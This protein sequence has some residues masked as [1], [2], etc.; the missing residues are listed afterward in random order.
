MLCQRLG[1]I[2]KLEVS[3]FSDEQTP[4]PIPRG[5]E[6]FLGERVAAALALS[7]AFLLSVFPSLPQKSS[8]N[9]DK[10]TEV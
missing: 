8:H 2:H 7:E 6:I 5:E 1:A 4:Y 3:E 10:T 9:C